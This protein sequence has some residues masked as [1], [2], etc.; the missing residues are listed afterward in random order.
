MSEKKVM[1]IKSIVT[2]V[3]SGLVG[4]S[5]AEPMLYN[6]SFESGDFVG[7]ETHGKGWSINGKMASEGRVSAMCGVQKGEEPTLKACSQKINGASAG[8]RISVSMDVA[9]IAVQQTPNTKA[10]II[11]LCVDENG[12]AL[13]EF[14]H[15]LVDLKAQFQKVKI[16]IAIVPEDS[17]ECHLMLIVENDQ[18]AKDG[19]WWRFDN[20]NI[21]IHN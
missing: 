16:P 1:K 5:L 15:D 18:V 2:I 9:A 11:I 20:V 19:D 13:K 14:R 17:A 10:S 21:Q 6:R 4:I 3:L 7:W 12:T 8:K